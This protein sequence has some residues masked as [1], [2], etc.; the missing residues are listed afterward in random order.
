M[1]ASD[2]S[3]LLRPTLLVLF[4]LAIYYYVYLSYLPRRRLKARGI[5]LPPG[6]KQKWLIGNLHQ[7]AAA[8]TEPWLTFASWG[9]IYGPLVYLRVLNKETIII[10]S[11]KAAIE[12]LESRSGV[13]SDRPTQWMGGELAGRKYS[14]FLTSSTDPRFRFFR[15]LLHNGLNPRASKDYRPIQLQE[16]RVLLQNLAQSP[17]NLALHIRRNAVATILKVAYGYEVKSNDDPLVHLLEHGF[18]LAAGISVPGKYWVEFFPILR[19]IPSWFPGAGFKRQ[20]RLVG[21]EM[22]GIET[23]PFKWA[24][25]QIESGDFI[26]SFTSKHILEGGKELD[27]SA[28]DDIKWC[29]AAL[30][31]GG[32]DTTVSAMLTFFLIMSLHPEIQRRAQRDVDAVASDRLP[33]YEDFENL[34]YIRALIKEVLRWGTV[35]PLGIPHKAME[36]DIYENYFIPKDAN[37]TANIWAITHDDEIY[38]DPDVFDPERHLGNPEE[39]QPDPF[40][41]IFG[42]G[43]RVCPGAHLAEMAL[44]LNISSILAAFDISKAV[45]ERGVPIEP[46]IE[47]S[48]GATRHLKPFPCQITLRSKDRLALFE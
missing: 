10:N 4:A 27:Q 40:K 39:R 38:P 48:T 23:T 8:K 15:R 46:N 9:K 32:G 6:P 35:A 22:S 29:A 43:R 37:I 30:Y 14:V 33:T 2:E 16:N 26:E 5:S 36:P 18:K 3:G 31:V 1:F 45:D 7:L 21:R 28:L 34:P 19:Y 13:T 24:K 44:F 25:K 41:F 12:L 47:W 20:A 11:G 42:F 17:Q